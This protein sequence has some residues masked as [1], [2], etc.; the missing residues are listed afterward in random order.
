MEFPGFDPVD[1]FDSIVGFDI[2]EPNGATN[3]FDDALHGGE[4]SPS[5]LDSTWSS[6]PQ[7]SEYRNRSNP[8]TL[9]L[10]VREIIK[11]FLYETDEK[12]LMYRLCLK[13][14]HIFIHHLLS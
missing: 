3:V 14:S 7:D 9:T 10:P 4:T 13:I 8:N 11:S 6:N 5:Q 12:A 1:H 2:T